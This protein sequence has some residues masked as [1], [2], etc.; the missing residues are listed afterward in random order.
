MLVRGFSHQT[1]LIVAR[2]VTLFLLKS[3]IPLPGLILAAIA[4]VSHGSHT[5]CWARP[6]LR[7]GGL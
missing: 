3:L 1:L 2:Q 6:I 7:E 4:I 5:R